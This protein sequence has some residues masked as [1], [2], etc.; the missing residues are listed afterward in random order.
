MPQG[1]GRSAYINDGYVQSAYLQGIPR[2]FPDVR[3]DYRQALTQARSV[4][5]RQMDLAEND[6]R[7]LETIGAEAIK[8]HVIKWDITKWDE[9]KKEDVAVTIEVS[10]ILHLQPIL[11]R[12]IF[13][14]IM[15]ELAPDEDPKLTAAERDITAAEDYQRALRGEPA[16]VADAKN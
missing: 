9:A 8:S 3:F 4:I 5:K 1:N 13:R 15:G 12:A 11:M 6:P 16:E 10:E 14:I 2:L 7:K